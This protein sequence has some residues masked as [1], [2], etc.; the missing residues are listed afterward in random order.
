M[1]ALHVTECE[2][3]SVQ[4][5]TNGSNT[6]LPA[7]PHQ[8]D[9]DD[10]YDRPELPSLM[11]RL[12][13]LSAGSS[14]REGAGSSSGSAPTSAGAGSLSTAVFRVS[15]H[16]SSSPVYAYTEGRFSWWSR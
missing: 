4:L 7:I 10:N 12:V 13:A 14:G 2:L 3:N 8:N 11:G 6:F 16:C 9:G 1:A 5:R 15:R